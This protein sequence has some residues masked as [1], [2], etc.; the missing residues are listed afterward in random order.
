MACGRVVNESVAV[1]LVSQGAS[2]VLESQSGA[3]DIL[4]FEEE[5]TDRS[6]GDGAG[7]ASLSGSMDSLNCIACV[8][9]GGDAEIGF[10]TADHSEQ[11]FFLETRG[12][13]R[14]AWSIEDCQCKVHDDSV[15]A[16]RGIV[17]EPCKWRLCHF[18]RAESEFARDCHVGRLTSWL[19]PLARMKRV[20]VD[21]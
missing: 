8:R 2:W 5:R 16:R 9:Q 10:E 20:I 12:P 7:L 13:R 14:D 19:S 4:G 6:P 1:V 18:R 17:F 11:C 3:E 15:A 21:P